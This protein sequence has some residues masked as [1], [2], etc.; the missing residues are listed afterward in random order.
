MS[1]EKQ[2][3]SEL[4][5]GEQNPFGPQSESMRQLLLFDPQKLGAVSVD[6]AR[7]MQ[8]VPEQSVSDAH[9]SYEQLRMNAPPPL[10]MQRP[11]V[12]CV[13]SES[14]EHDPRLPPS[15]N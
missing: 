14:R 9:V 15:P 13:Q 7:Q 2:N 10:G 4:S 12:P 3:V 1:A 5:V 6:D 8:T 11:F